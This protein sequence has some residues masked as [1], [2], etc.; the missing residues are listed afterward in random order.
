MGLVFCNMIG[1]FITWLRPFHTLLADAGLPDMRF[2]DLR[3]SMATILLVAGIHPKVVQERLG[4]SSI[5]MTMDVYSHVLPSMQEDVARK[6]D[7]MLEN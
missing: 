6:F 3:H 1:G 7:E 5:A 4:H 2:H